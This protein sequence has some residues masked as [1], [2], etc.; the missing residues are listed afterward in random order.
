MARR[1]KKG[2]LSVYLNSRFVGRLR[3]ESSGAIDF[4]YDQSW[5]D[6]D[7]AFPVSLSLPLREDRFIGAPVIAV[8]DNL[9]PDNKDIRDRLAE[10][11]QAEGTDA[12]SLLTA[13]GRDCV[14]AL[15]FLPEGASPGK[16]GVVKGHK[17]SN[18]EIAQI[19]KDLK[20]SPLGVGTKYTDFRISIAG[21]H[22][23]TALLFWKKQWMIPN[24][25][26]ATT[27][28]LKP[29]IGKL[30]NGIDLS[31]SVENEYLCLK[32]V[33]ALGVPAASTQI[34]DF[35]DR[36][37]LAVQRFDRVKTKDQRLLRLPQEDC[38]QALSVPPTLKYEKDGGPSVAKILELLKGSDDPNKDRSTFLKSQVIF[39]LLCATDG[40][41]KNFSLRIAPGGRFGLTPLYDV[42]SAQPFLDAHT[43]KF[44]EAKLAMAVGTKRHYRVNTVLPR[45]FQQT[46]VASG[47]SDNVM[48]EIFEELA[49]TGEH[50]I[51]GVI[52]G[53]PK[54][55]PEKLTESVTVGA[56]KRLRTMMD[57]LKAE[58][59]A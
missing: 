49:E 38:C 42:L 56:K 3:R 37:V 35:E 55:F 15:Q 32:L 10:K 46:A 17:I 21:A 19:L 45:H 41:A 28:I 4:Q 59:A 52:N 53:L 27:H 13:V 34:A 29:P 51:D 8:F 39:W 30:E 9:L 44:N 11:T 50:A 7:N 12:F 24:G 47:I 25:T 31:D 57:A 23:K 58:K 33:A 36:R 18:S 22:E 1:R 6:W 5:L 40:H 54:D 14:G 48:T 26:T 2:P 20:C 16:A 43:L